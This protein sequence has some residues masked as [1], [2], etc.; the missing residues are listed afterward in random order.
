MA[1]CFFTNRSIRASL[2]T[3]TLPLVSTCDHARLATNKNNTNKYLY[4]AYC[5]NTRQ[6][7]RQTHH[8]QSLYSRCNPACPPLHRSIAVPMHKC[9]F[10]PRPLSAHLQA[11]APASTAPPP[12]SPPSPHIL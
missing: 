5:F 9:E 10:P 12:P 2:V 3:T 7:R 1:I 4:I 8:A 11:D 6:N